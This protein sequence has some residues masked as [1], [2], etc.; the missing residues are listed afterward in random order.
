M[1]EYQIILEDVLKFASKYI[2]YK[3]LPEVLSNLFSMFWDYFRI[4]KFWV[5]RFAI[6]YSLFDINMAT[7]AFFLIFL[8]L[9]WGLLLPNLLMLSV[10]H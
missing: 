10:Y 6:K 5:E 7:L 4:I 2:D 3:F 1:H 9:Y 8:K